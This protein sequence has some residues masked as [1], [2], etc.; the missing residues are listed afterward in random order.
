MEGRLVGTQLL[1]I[2][3]QV[4][5]LAL[6]REQVWNRV[7]SCVKGEGKRRYSGAH[8]SKKDCGSDQRSTKGIRELFWADGTAYLELQH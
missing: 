2:N 7:C 8:E 1:G 6:L 5:I 3:L 4:F